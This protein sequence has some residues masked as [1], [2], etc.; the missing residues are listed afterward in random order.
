MVKES[1]QRTREATGG[2]IRYSTRILIYSLATYLGNGITVNKASPEVSRSQLK[3]RHFAPRESSLAE[4]N[5]ELV[6]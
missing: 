5:T 4:T 1:R 2:V 6:Q 3:C